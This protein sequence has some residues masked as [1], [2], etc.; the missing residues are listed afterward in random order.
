V[1]HPPACQHETAVEQQSTGSQY[2]PRKSGALS[3]LV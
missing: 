2:T 3:V 1:G